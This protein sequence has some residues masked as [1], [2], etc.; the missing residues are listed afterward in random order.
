MATSAAAWWPSS[1]L[2]RS[3][4]SAPYRTAVWMGATGL[5][6]PWHSST[7]FA[8]CLSVPMYKS[9]SDLH[10]PRYL[11]RKATVFSHN[12]HKKGR[13]GLFTLKD[14]L[15]IYRFL[16]LIIMPRYLFFG[17]FGSIGEPMFF[18]RSFTPNILSIRAKT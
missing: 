18:P 14:R 15:F 4:S 9:Y 3:H 17:A 1:H 11:G 2:K 5:S 16:I 8:V 13:R 6:V 7:H 10:H 12:R